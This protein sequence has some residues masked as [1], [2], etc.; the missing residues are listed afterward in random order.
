MQMHTSNIQLQRLYI[1]IPEGRKQIIARK[2]LDKLKW[3]ASRSNFKACISMCDAKMVFRMPNP[4]S[5]VYL[6][7]PSVPRLDLLL[8]A[9]LLGRCL[10][11]LASPNSC[12]PWCNPGFIFTVSHT[13][14]SWP[15]CRGVPDSQ[16][17]SA[18]LLS[19]EA[20][21]YSPFF[22]PCL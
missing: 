19:W 11:T 16:L 6:Q 18:A 5:F 3:M 21:F 2:Y 22:Y 13:G 7:R 12:C 14:L 9:D 20:R 1:F 10:M 4:I 15:P 17:A 8:L